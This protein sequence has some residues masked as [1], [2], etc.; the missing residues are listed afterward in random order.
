LQQTKQELKMANVNF[1]A[2][3]LETVSTASTKEVAQELL[4]AI[5]NKAAE[6]KYAIKPE[7]V[8]AL[9]RNIDNA[10]DKKEVIAIGWNMLLAGE[11]LAS[12]SSKYQRKYA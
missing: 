8:A 2:A 10:R 6:G 9:H 12:V 4:H 1:T 5:V 3:E 7:K 11:G